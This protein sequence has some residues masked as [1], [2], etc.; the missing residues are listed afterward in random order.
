MIENTN[1]IYKMSD[2]QEEARKGFFPFKSR[3][4]IRKLSI[5]GLM[6]AHFVKTGKYKRWYYI[7][8][9]IVE[10]LKTQQNK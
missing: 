1:K 2:L 4:T 7:G 5:N 3:I 9:E 8:S 6:P 10:W